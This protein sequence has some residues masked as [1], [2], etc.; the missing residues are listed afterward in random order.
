MLDFGRPQPFLS[1]AARLAAA[2]LLFGGCYEPFSPRRL[3]APSFVRPVVCAPR[4]LCAPSF[5]RPVALTLLLSFCLMPLPVH[6]GTWSFA[7]TSWS[8]THT[9]N[10]ATYG[11]LKPRNY[12]FEIP[13]A[14]GQDN[15]STTAEAAEN[16]TVTATYIPNPN[17]V[18]DTAPPSTIIA[19]QSSAHSDG[20][21]N[22]VITPG[23]DADDGLGDPVNTSGTSQ[24]THYRVETGNTFQVTLK[25]RASY[26]NPSGVAEAVV[27]GIGFSIV[28]GG[29]AGPYYFHK[30]RFI[31]TNPSVT[32]DWADNTSGNYPTIQDRSD[33]THYFLAP[34]IN[35][36]GYIESQGSITPVWYWT[37]PNL[38][39]P[40]PG[41]DITVVTFSVVR[42]HSSNTPVQLHADDGQGNTLLSSPPGSLITSDTSSSSVRVES[43]VYAPGEGNGYWAIGSP[44]NM[45]GY[46]SDTIADPNLDASVELD[47]TIKSG[48]NK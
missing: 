20:I 34:T 38:G 8:Y 7:A 43:D 11:T 14:G 10:G 42:D 22:H 36:G 24:G 40:P 30:G 39:V 16:L 48:N 44:I 21:V 46:L 4:R 2:T 25:L 23:S 31:A 1:S 32:Q 5:V 41:F 6:A 13:A 37:G 26:T 17:I 27:G 28:N 33:N 29:W 12:G 45:D 19:I 35:S 9:L 18:G 3:C 15:A 47:A